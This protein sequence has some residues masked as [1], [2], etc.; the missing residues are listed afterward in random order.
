MNINN[1]MKKEI[2]INYTNGHNNK[3][4]INYTN[5]IPYTSCDLRV[6]L[7]KENIKF[8]NFNFKH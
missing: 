8:A 5:G 3:L 1:L 4:T 6:K 2:R 7:M